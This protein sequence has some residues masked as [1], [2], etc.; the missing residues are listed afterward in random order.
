MFIVYTWQVSVWAAD[1]GRT[2]QLTDC[3]NLILSEELSS[4]AGESIGNWRFMQ[5][6]K[7]EAWEWGLDVLIVK[8]EFNTLALV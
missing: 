3:L 5:I 1:R 4:L 8:Q 7:M 2:E 6:C